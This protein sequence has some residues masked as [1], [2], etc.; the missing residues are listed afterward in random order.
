MI[1][2]IVYIVE[3]S[4]ASFIEIQKILHYSSFPYNP[5]VRH[6]KCT[7]SSAGR[8]PVFETEGRRFDPCRVHH[9]FRSSDR[10]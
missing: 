9:Y 10:P 5:S 1:F 3:M 6:I 7:R 4:I 2:F 8:V